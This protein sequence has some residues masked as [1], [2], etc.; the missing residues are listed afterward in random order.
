M[1]SAVGDLPAEGKH[2]QMR[3][4]SVK[5][6]PNHEICGMFEMHPCRLWKNVLFC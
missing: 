5:E 4:K 6:M 3:F 2:P 1:L